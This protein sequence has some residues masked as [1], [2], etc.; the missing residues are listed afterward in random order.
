MKKN[1][2]D[3]NQLA[4]LDARAEREG[5]LAQ[6]AGFRSEQLTNINSLERE[7]VDLI[8]EATE[9]ELDYYAA[10]A[11]AA[12]KSEAAKKKIKRGSN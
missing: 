7:R 3:E 11:D 6:I 2:N 8:K 10:A 1:G 9:A 5:I 4:L 12:I